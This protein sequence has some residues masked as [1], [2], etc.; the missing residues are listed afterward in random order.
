MA[1]SLLKNYRIGGD[2]IDQ[3]A[4]DVE[5][6]KAKENEKRTVEELIDEEPIV[7]NFPKDTTPKKPVTTKPVSTKPELL[8]FDLQAR[9][10]RALSERAEPRAF[11]ES[12]GLWKPEALKRFRVG[13]C[14]GKLLDVLSDEQRDA[15]AS[16]GILDDSGAEAFANCLT[17]PFFGDQGRIA[18]FYG[19]SVSGPQ[20]EILVPADPLG[21]INRECAQPY[22][23]RII[24]THSVLD[25]LAFE[26]IGVHSAI[27]CI[28]SGVLSEAHET[29]FREERV[30]P[31]AIAFDDPEA[32]A[33]LA[34][35]LQALSIPSYRLKPPQGA[36]N[37]PS[38]Q[39]WNAFL[40]S[41]I[42]KKTVDILV[43]DALAAFN[44]TS[45]GSPS[46]VTLSGKR[47]TRDGETKGNALAFTVKTEAMAT[48]F[49]F[50]DL[51]Y[52]VSGVKEIF[53]SSLK[54]NVRAS[55]E[56]RDDALY[57]NFDLYAAAGRTRYAA[58]VA[59]RFDVEAARV[60]RD[61][62]AILEYLEAERNK[63]LS[64]PAVQ[65]VV[66]TEDERKVAM[67]FLCSPNLFDEILADMEKLG[68]VGEPLNKLI[69]YLAATSRKMADPLSV[70]II[71][72]SASGKSFLVDT[73]RKLMPPEDVI[74]V[75]SLSDQALNYL[76]D[77]MH[78]FLVLGEA[79]HGDVVEH[80]LREML[81]AK[82]LARMVAVKDPETGKYGS[83]IVRTPAVVASVMSTTNAQVNAENASRCFVINADESREQT[84]TIHKAQREKY[85]LDRYRNEETVIPAIVAKHRAAQRL[86]ENVAIVNGFSRHLDF[87]DTLMRTRRDH[88]RFLDL[89]AAVCF[90]R[91]F[92]KEAKEE[93]GLRYVSCDIE[94]YKIAYR[95]MVD[96]VLSSTM[97]DL[98]GGAHEL[99]EALRGIARGR[100]EAEGIK[101]EEVR[102]TQREI[103][104]ATGYGQ[105]WVREQ[106]RRL[107]DYEYVGTARGYVRGER[108]QYRI[109]HDEEIPKLDLSMIPTPEAM[110]AKIRHE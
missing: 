42:S 20:R 63:K 23:D 60:E 30:S 10:E 34:E 81:S 75:T 5:R 94:D 89:I 71:S 62:V 59:R 102:L 74:A 91:Q 32:S 11:L 9:Y 106:M 17:F 54:V 78:K 110:E 40:R 38:K 25:A 103:R 83:M 92:Q 39:T 45:D 37:P 80:Q 55:S 84:R 15:F 53:V 104:E 98:P 100:G 7:V 57:D 107:V 50:K 8:Y 43:E 72:Q 61:L 21:L 12:L 2:I 66:V 82:E 95:I 13:Y 79:V 36:L 58:A 70:I 105:S 22:R 56:D 77:L 99:Y 6:E 29:L 101:P 18:G 64:R 35:R 48:L 31:I 67:A 65:A 27:P 28:S 44:T 69:L 109:L 76:I 46:D 68:Y 73:V 90:L 1:K 85:T 3:V 87:P 14:D 88:E 24:L 93:N 96:G 97:R 49:D 47:E 86:L 4:A 52:R 33:A 41:G 51:R 16:L 19:L 26:A 108:S